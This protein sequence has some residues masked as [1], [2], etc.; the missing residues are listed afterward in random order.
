MT[1]F[2]VALEEHDLEQ[3]SPSLLCGS[4]FLSPALTFFSPADFCI[5]CVTCS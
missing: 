5:F 2:F 3:H 4:N 1:N